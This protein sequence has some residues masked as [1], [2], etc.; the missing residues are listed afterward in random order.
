MEA[1]GPA[2]RRQAEGL[3]YSGWIDQVCR[4]AKEVG[5][6]AGQGYFACHEGGREF[7]SHMVHLGASSSVDRAPY[8]LVR[9]FP[10][11][12]FLESCGRAAEGRSGKY[13]ENECVE[14]DVSGANARGSGGAEGQREGGASPDRAD[15]PAL[16]RCVLRKRS[17][18]RRA[19]RGACSRQ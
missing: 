8:V 13:G 4:R 6:G 14:P 2:C 12:N 10:S 3:S 18:Y 16:G 19:D 1:S 7:E 9:L 15:V 17:G 11:S 5:R